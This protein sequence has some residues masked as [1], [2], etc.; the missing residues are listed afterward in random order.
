MRIDA[1]EI[2]RVAMPLIYPYGTAFGLEDA[3]ETVLVK[4]TSGNDHGWGEGASWK[5]PGYCAECAATQFVIS[6]DHV[7]PLLLGAEVASGEDVQERLACI[8]DNHFAKGGFDLA[9]WDLAAKQAGKP[10][11]QMLGGGGPTVDAGAAFGTMERV[12]DLVRWVG[13]ALEAGYLRIKLKFHP[14]W[15]LFMLEAVRQAFPDAVV[16]IDCNSAYS[17]DDLAMFQEVDRFDLAMIEQPLAHNDLLDHAEL[18]A[19]IKTPICLDESIKTVKH[20]R[21][22]IKLGS[23]RWVNIKPG[24]VGGITVARRIHD[25]CQ[26]ADLPCWI[27][28]M[29]ESAIGSAH[30]LALATLPNIRYPSDI[31]PTDRGYERDLATPPTVHSAPSQFTANDGPGIGVEPDPEMLE[32]CTLERAAFTA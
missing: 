13:E 32:R 17:L 21:Q 16:H 19:K 26:E 20:A 24:R 29:L 28:G 10:L 18:Q 30:M 6:R 27:G 3:I 12:E 11:W 25:V 8:K 2:Y 9:W 5:H 4:L 23:C 1:I 22:A 14:G 7:A 31:L 15:D